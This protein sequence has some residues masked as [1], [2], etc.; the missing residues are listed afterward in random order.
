ML[1]IAGNRVKTTEDVMPAVCQTTDD[2]LTGVDLHCNR[3]R[4]SRLFGND[5]RVFRAI[6]LCTVYHVTG[7]T[8]RS[9]PATVI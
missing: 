4:P 7:K 1:E 6:S 3:N 8:R 2:P 5:T 9:T